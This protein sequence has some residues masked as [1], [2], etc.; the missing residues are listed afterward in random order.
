MTAAAGTG[1][2]IVAGS[3]AFRAFGPGMAMAVFI[4]MLVAVT[5]VPALLA[6]LGSAAL[7]SPPRPVRPTGRPSSTPSRPAGG[8]RG[9][10]TRPWSRAVVLVLCVGGLI[11]AALPLRD[12]TLGVSFVEALPASHPA[13]QAAAQAETGFADGILSPTE[14]LVQG[15]GRGV[16]TGGAGPAAAVARGEPGVAAVLGPGAEA[17]PEELNLFQAPDGTAARYL[18]VLS[19]EPLGAR[20]IDTLTRLQERPARPA[21]RR[22]PGR[23]RDQPRR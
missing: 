18:L 19:D 17:I 6:I 2:L 3:P 12:L 10:L 1:A 16:A 13:R 23:R 4:G 11:A 8:G 21:G 7:W 9:L 22:R 20:A 15:A 14:L 5:L